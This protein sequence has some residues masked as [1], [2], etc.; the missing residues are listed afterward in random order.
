MK[1]ILGSVSIREGVWILNFSNVKATPAFLCKF[2]IWILPSMFIY[3]LL[4][5]DLHLDNKRVFIL[6]FSEQWKSTLV[7]LAEI[8]HWKINFQQLQITVKKKHGKKKNGEKKEKERKWQKNEELN[9]TFN[10]HHTS[11][12]IYIGIVILVLGI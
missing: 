4:S 6:M 11:I 9:C 1:H 5:E 3:Q 8:S 10:L 7:W 2:K 12:L